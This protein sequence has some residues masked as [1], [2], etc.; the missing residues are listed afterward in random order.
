MKTS[1]IPRLK[2]YLEFHL[3]EVLEKLESNHQADS[4]ADPTWSFWTKRLLQSR[5]EIS[6]ALTRIRDG[7]YG[8]CVGCGNEIGL[9]R[10]EVAPWAQFCDGCQ[11]E[12][13]QRQPA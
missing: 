3:V 13:E 2:R 6:S 8:N 7:T 5:E 1:E 12:S 4:D 10:L 11:E 9:S